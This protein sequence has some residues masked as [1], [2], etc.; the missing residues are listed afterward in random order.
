MG[1]GE[2]I[3]GTFKEKAGEATDNEQLRQEGQAQ[4]AKGAAEVKETEHRA[5]AQ[6]HEKKAE[7]L[8]EQADNL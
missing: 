7:S 6:E 8:Q 1:I 5:K 4:D 2:R 3:K